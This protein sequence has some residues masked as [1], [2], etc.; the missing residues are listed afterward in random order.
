ML[1]PGP[2]STAFWCERIVFETLDA[3]SRP[4]VS[5]CSRS[6]PGEAVHAIR[7]DVRALVGELS[8]AERVRALRWTG[9]G[10]CVGA[11]AALYRGEPCGFSL[12]GSG[13]RWFEWTVRPY[14]VF[15]VSDP[16][17]LCDTEAP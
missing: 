1:R 4:H 7:V 5:R 9:P 8:P 17:L 12:S 14:L 15:D 11:V 2:P 3:D 6:D 16:L 10:A 13:G